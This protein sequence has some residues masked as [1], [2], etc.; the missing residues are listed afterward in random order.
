MLNLDKLELL[1]Q[2]HSGVRTY[3]KLQKMYGY[4]SVAGVQ[5]MLRPLE[6]DGFL[7]RG[8]DRKLKVDERKLEDTF[9]NL[10]VYINWFRIN[11]KTIKTVQTK[12]R[13]PTKVVNEKGNKIRK[14]KK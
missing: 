7:Y 1:H 14:I 12:I 9:K 10:I 2:I 5:T 8:E 13:K 3:G 4:K 11:Y 6:R